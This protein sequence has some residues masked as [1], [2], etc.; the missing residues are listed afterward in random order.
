MIGHLLAVSLL[1]P[2][3]T[4]NGCPE[5]CKCV[6]STVIC[7]GRRTIPDDFPEKSR[8]LDLRKNYFPTISSRAFTK[9][10]SLAHWTILPGKL[11][12]FFLE[13]FKFVLS[14]HH[15]VQNIFLNQN[16]LETFPN[17][18]FSHMEN[19]EKL[20]IEHNKITTLVPEMFRELTHLDELEIKGNPF[21]CNCDLKPFTNFISARF[22]LKEMPS[23]TCEH[24][25]QLKSMNIIEGVSLANCEE[26]IVP[27]FDLLGES[28]R[29]KPSDITVSFG[30]PVFFPCSADGSVSWTKNGVVINASDRVNII[31]TGLEIPKV[32]F[33]DSGE[34]TCSVRSSE[35][36]LTAS[37]SLK[38]H[39]W[40]VLL[41]QNNQKLEKYLGGTIIAICKFVS[42]PRAT[43]TWLKD[44]KRVTR[45]KR[46]KITGTVDGFAVESTL[47][48]Y[49]AGQ[50]EAGIYTCNARNPDGY[51]SAQITVIMKKPVK[52]V[53]LSSTV[54]ISFKSGDTVEIPCDVFGDPLPSMWISKDQKK[55]ISGGRYS[56]L[57]KKLV[58][59]DAREDDS[60]LYICNGRNYAGRESK[61]V[62]VLFT[63]NTS[64]NRIADRIHDFGLIGGRDVEQIVLTASLNVRRAVNQ[65]IARLKKDSA[66]PEVPVRTLFALAKFPTRPGLKKAVAAEI[67]EETVRLAL[68][69]LEPS[70]FDPDA[71][72]KKVANHLTEQDINDLRELAGCDEHQLVPNC[73]ENMCFHKKFRSIDG[74]CNN[75]DNPLWGSATTPLKRLLI[76]IYENDFNE[77]VGWN[78]INYGS[79]PLPSSREVSL[80][81]LKGHSWEPD[82][83]FS[84]MLM[85]W[86]QFL[87]HD[88]TLT[89]MSPSSTHFGRNTLCRDECTNAA[90]CFPIRKSTQETDRLHHDEIQHGCL[91][92]PSHVAS[93]LTQLHL[94]ST[95]QMYTG[96]TW[97]LHEINPHWT[98]E[99]K[100]LETRKIIGAIIQKVTYNEWLPKIL[101]EDGMK[102]LGNY[103]GYNPRENPS[104]TN[105][106]ATAA[107]R[108]GHSLIKP[109]VKRLDEN[110]QPH[111]VYGDL[112]LYKAF[113]NPYQL[114]KRG[115]IDP[116]IRGLVFTGSKDKRIELN[117]PMNPQLIERLFESSDRVA[118]DLGALNIQRGRDHAL[119]FYSDW[120]KHCGLAPVS[121]WS[122]LENDFENEVVEKMKSL[123]ASVEYIEL[124]PALVL[125]K[126][127]HGTRT[128]PTLQCLLV[129]QFRKLRSGDRFWYQRPGEFSPA[130][131]REIEKI[132]LGQ[133]FCENGDDISKMSTNVFLMSAP[134]VPC[135]HLIEQ[136]SLDLEKWTETCEHKI[137]V[138]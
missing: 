69:N 102:K 60:G 115:G 74:T 2:A 29:T 83:D 32:V 40:P 57:E 73:E 111:S 14:L 8:I 99:E 80:V 106:F 67:F 137:I 86:G 59:Y 101:G 128:G 1:L 36:K 126:T 130:Q 113:F 117:G 107:F 109:V 110:L 62:E 16:E 20:N 50:K 127:I 120:R 15:R 78:D 75:L 79:K 88:I 64:A 94:L 138:Q 116:I 68:Q 65:T 31:S 9:Q 123:Y 27:N 44:G 6:Q 47:K 5:K 19:L 37:G 84:G 122:D 71:E 18:L 104:V 12:R 23:A 97:R 39:S 38:V 103:T 56:V 89:A 70:K 4:A 124:F 46:V 77:P 76:P 112:P 81:L 53:I 24:P 98:G 13:L 10:S 93:K 114:F 134:Q 87:D 129:D 132:T 125:E 96:P 119:P 55:I 51:A 25:A 63:K 58:I 54:D 90:P 21:G 131:L 34:Y 49:R 133:I 100:Y 82:P 95:P 7:R 48:V 35:G 135:E 11:E 121:D 17:D 66:T 85:Q 61:P 33:S 26:T 28:F 43:V 105:V 41:S 92:I 72:V 3:L 30:S 108:F 52:P 91:L 136:D 118:L 45:S 22:S 42:N